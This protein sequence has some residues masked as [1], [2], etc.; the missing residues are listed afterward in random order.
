MIKIKVIP[1]ARKPNFIIVTR[2]GESFF[3]Y[4]L[5]DLSTINKHSDVGVWKIKYLK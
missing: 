1:I 4:H 5:D 2:F 3:L